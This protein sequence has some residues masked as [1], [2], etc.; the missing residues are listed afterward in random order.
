MVVHETT[1]DLASPRIDGANE[2]AFIEDAPIIWEQLVAL[3]ESAP[4][5]TWDHVPADLSK[6]IDGLIYRREQDPA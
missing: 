2:L 5:G 3:G 6:R 4:A 1:I